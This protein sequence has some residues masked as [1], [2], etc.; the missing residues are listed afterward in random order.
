MFAFSKNT[1]SSAALQV[2]LRNSQGV[3]NELLVK[4]ITLQTECQLARERELALLELLDFYRKEALER[5]SAPAEEIA[6]PEIINASPTTIKSSGVPL[7]SAGSSPRLWS[8]PVRSEL[9]IKEEYILEGLEALKTLLTLSATPRALSLFRTTSQTEAYRVSATSLGHISDL[10]TRFAA[11]VATLRDRCVRS[12]DELVTGVLEPFMADATSTLN[13]FMDPSQPNPEYPME[14]TFRFH[15][16][17]KILQ[18]LCQQSR[19][20]GFRASACFHTLSPMV[21]GC[22]AVTLVHPGGSWKGLQRCL[23]AGLSGATMLEGDIFNLVGMASI[24]ESNREALDDASW[25][26]VFQDTDVVDV[27]WILP[28]D[29]DYVHDDQ[30]EETESSPENASSEG[31]LTSRASSN[32][33]SISE[34]PEQAEETL[35][36][37]DEGPAAEPEALEQAEAASTELGTYS[38]RSGGHRYLRA[39]EG[40]NSSPHSSSLISVKVDLRYDS[41]EPPKGPYT[42]LK[43]GDGLRR[44]SGRSSDLSIRKKEVNV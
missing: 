6:I 28:G 2:D 34:V 9:S 39:G 18:M 12:Q 7:S 37:A 32:A 21:N 25:A 27:F 5:A 43:R 42:F 4:I 3:S 31:S 23:F 24:H 44:R 1:S 22:L 26:A 17:V 19:C 38:R 29:C 30:I 41:L 36:I 8:S 11:D 20:P 33:H 10:A 16:L 14:L 13:Q 40:V 15:G 35:E